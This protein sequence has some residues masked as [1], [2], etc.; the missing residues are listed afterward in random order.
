MARLCCGTSWASRRSTCT[1]WCCTGALPSWPRAGGSRRSSTRYSRPTATRRRWRSGC[2]PPP[3]LEV[4]HALGPGVALHVAPEPVDD[5]RVAAGHVR[6]L[7][8][9]RVEALPAALVVRDQQP[10]PVGGGHVVVVGRGPVAALPTRLT[11]VEQWRQVHPV[12]VSGDL[13]SEHG[14]HRRAHVV[15]GRE[16]LALPTRGLPRGVPDQERHVAQ[17]VV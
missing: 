7:V 5:L 10:A 13:L 15:R 8:A 16:V 12:H 4:R 14:Q 17:L 2:G 1:G 3:L 9:H 6:A 11:A